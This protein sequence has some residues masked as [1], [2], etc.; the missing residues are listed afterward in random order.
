MELFLLHQ[1]VNIIISSANM[2]SRFAMLS[3]T[4]LGWATGF[5]QPP[6]NLDVEGVPPIPPE[7]RSSIGRYLEFRAASFN[8]WHP[9]RRELLIATR[10]ADATQL[11][12][13]KMPGGARRQITFLPEPVAYGMFDPNDGAFVVFNQD[14]GGGE[15]FQ[16]YR[17]D[18]ADGRVTLLTD[19]KSRNLDPSWSK[20]GTLLAYTSTRRNGRD[21]DIY[22]MNPRDPKSDRM[23]APVE[24]GGWRIHDWSWEGSELLLGEYIS[25]NESRLH[26]CDA[27]TGRMKLLT[28]KSAEKSSWPAG[29]FAKD[30]KSLFVRT[31][32]DSEFLRQIGRAHV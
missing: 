5:A 3:L 1:H 4:V 17:Y 19:G 25:I 24:G 2:N 6:V 29:A 26:L 32:Q 9:T 7:L 22:V 18:L 16:F 13:V 21:T 31:D 30:A 23:L 12:L 28:P 10:F 15:F 8:D 20:D 11:H 14:T 27:K